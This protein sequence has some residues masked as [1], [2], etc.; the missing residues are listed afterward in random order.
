[1][2]QSTRMTRANDKN[3]KET[4]PPG[5]SREFSAR[6]SRLKP[7]QKVRAVVL[8]R[9]G[10]SEPSTASRQ[11]PSSRREK[12]A[13]VRRSVE[14]ALPDIDRVLFEHAGRRLSASADA[15][16]SIAVE[17]TPAGIRALADSEHVKAVLE[18][19]AVGILS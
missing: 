19:Q 7:G 18:D 16:G 15:L 13:A 9:V 6:L 10:D 17:A 14:A 2:L 5:I 11:S 8:L 1:M 12:I 4:L 3:L